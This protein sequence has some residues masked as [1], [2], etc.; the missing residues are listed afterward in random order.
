MSAAYRLGRAILPVL[1]A[2]LLPSTVAAQADEWIGVGGTLALEDIRMEGFGNGD[3]KLT[4]LLYGVEGR[5]SWWRVYAQGEFRQGRLSQDHLDGS[6]AR[7]VS[8]RASVGLK[9]LPGVV[10]AAGPRWS[11]VGT[12]DGTRRILRW[13]AELIGR[14]PLIPD[15]ASGFA[16]LSG[17][18]AGTD[19]DGLAGFEGGGGEVGLL[20]APTGRPVWARVGYRLE[21]ESLL[22]GSSHTA[23]TA[24]LSVGVSVP[25]SDTRWERP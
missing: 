17:S 8:A 3:E 12:P 24:F 13:R 6:S 20:V 1:V 10:I 9:V 18:V 2:L 4:G 7:A 5:I 11:S 19:V 14:A 22:F 21:R 16:T 23:E 15:V 25:R